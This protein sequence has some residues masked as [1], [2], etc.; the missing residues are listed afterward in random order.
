M[1]NWPYHTNIAGLASYTL[2]TLLMIGMLTCVYSDREV[3]LQA[4]GHVIDTVK[5]QVT[6]TNS[7]QVPQPFLRVIHM[8]VLLQV[9]DYVI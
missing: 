5:V 1:S 3:D 2:T 7:F 4:G 6:D 8:R 9:Y